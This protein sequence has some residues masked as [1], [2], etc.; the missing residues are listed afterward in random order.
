MRHDAAMLQFSQVIQGVDSHTAGEPTRI[1]TGGLPPIAGASMADKR[2]TL[3][4]DFDHLRRALVLEPRG[5]DAIVLAY[6]LPPCAEGAHL[7]V[8]GFHHAVRVTGTVESSELPPTRTLR[9]PRI[10]DHRTVGYVD[11][12][13]HSV[14]VDGTPPNLDHL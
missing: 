2:A 9:E 6:L 5:H 11:E 4:R 1:V 14:P 12:G 7:G 3:Q 10:D 8:D 13:E